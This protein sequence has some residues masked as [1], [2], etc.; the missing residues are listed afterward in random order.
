MKYIIIL[1]SLISLFGCAGVQRSQFDYTDVKL[2]S[3]VKTIKETPDKISYLKFINAY[4]TSSQIK[5]TKFANDE[6]KKI[7][8]SIKM[9]TMNC[10]QYD[11][12]KLTSL[13][14]V[15]IPAHLL[16]IEC[17]EKIG[18]LKQKKEHENL[19][20]FLVTGILGEHSGD[21]YYDAYEIST[22]GDAEDLL[23]YAGLEVID[24]YFEFK[25]NRSGMYRIYI[26]KEMNSNV[27]RKIYFD[28]QRFSHAFLDIQFPF[29]G[30]GDHMYKS[31]ILSLKESDYAAQL[32]HAQILHE[33]E[34][35]KE[36]EKAYLAAISQGSKKANIELGKLC[37]EG[38]ASSFSKTECA[39]LFVTASELGL[40][41]AKVYL[42]YMAYAGIGFDEDKSMGADV[43]NSINTTMKPGEP[44]YQI[45]LL[46][47]SSKYS[48][49]DEKQT[50]FFLDRAIKKEYPGALFYLLLSDLT[51]EGALATEEKQ[52][53]VIKNMTK[54]ADLGYIPAKYALVKY[55][56]EMDEDKSEALKLLKELADA[57]LPAALYDL[58]KIYQYGQYNTE[59]DELKAFLKYQQ[60]AIKWDAD[61]QLKL[62][63]MIGKGQVA[64]KD[65]ALSYG[66]YSLC[67]RV[68]N[69][70]C[71][72]N[73]GY[74]S[75]SGHGVEQDYQRALE[76]YQ[77][78]SDNGLSRA[79]YNLA[80]LYEH[81]RGVDKDL[82]KAL[83]YFQKAAGGG[84]SLAKNSLGLFS[85]KGKVEKKDYKKALKY[86]TEAASANNKY[87]YYNLGRIYQN[88]WGVNVDLD[89][90]YEFY[91]KAS[92]LGHYASS[93]RLAE[94][95]EQGLVFTKNNL[96]AIKYYQLAVK[97]GD[98]EAY[99]KMLRLCKIEKSC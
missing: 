4:L 2:N 58:G 21:N 70:D 65:Y 30:L 13:N 97:Q 99:P 6:Y 3:I 85:L 47:N 56:F 49:I 66:W 63:F 37:L 94:A 45:A 15:S 22:W 55:K 27:E 24:S 54:S 72:T 28:N 77:L 84:S 43:M 67:A 75:A 20:Q 10:E 12:A 80:I 51:V 38:H 86:F 17:F 79:T 14:I 87:G 89:K 32:A 1:I 88:G 36:A 73:L 81:G 95:Y 25:A 62:G 48:E 8:S 91:Q 23:E 68:G 11:W 60:A 83:E 39:Q 41:Q 64:E 69:L 46:F 61:A 82:N 96:E 44:D 92:A 71:I 33:G 16:A 29:S 50:R 53:T 52:E 57:N 40:E 26:T 59:K 9:G 93:F 78:A 90:A 7:A 74:I 18:D 76:L 31:I 34:K 19:V 35:Y 42:A 98:S 5:N